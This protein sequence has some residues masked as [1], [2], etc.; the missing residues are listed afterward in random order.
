MKQLENERRF[1]SATIESEEERTCMK[2]YKASD[3][4]DCRSI[5]SLQPNRY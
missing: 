1:M 2:I 3:N 5:H 4:A